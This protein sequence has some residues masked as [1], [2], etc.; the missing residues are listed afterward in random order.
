[1]QDRKQKEAN[2]GDLSVA[3][4]GSFLVIVHSTLGI[5]ER[6]STT[7]IHQCSFFH[8]SQSV[9]EVNRAKR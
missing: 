7:P 3:L 9:S 6:R 1:M 5:F 4:Q 8:R 2:N